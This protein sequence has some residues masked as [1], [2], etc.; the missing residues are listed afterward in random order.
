MQTLAQLLDAIGQSQQL[1]Q[2]D[3]LCACFRKDEGALGQ[4]IGAVTDAAGSASDAVGSALGWMKGKLRNQQAKT[5]LEVDEF[6]VDTPEVE[7]QKLLK[8]LAKLDRQLAAGEISTE[9]YQARWA[10]LK[11]QIP[12]DD[13]Y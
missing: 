5:E 12:D 11:A 13:Q 7:A 6:N 10:N 3:E 9:S 4:A 1:E 2:A 8:E